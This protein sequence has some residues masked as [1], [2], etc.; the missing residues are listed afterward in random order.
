[1]T[2]GTS[3][4]SASSIAAEIGK[5]QSNLSIRD[6][7]QDT[8]ILNPSNSRQTFTL[9]DTITLTTQDTAVADNMNLQGSNNFEM[10]E[11]KSYNKVNRIVFSSTSSSRVEHTETIGR[12]V[13]EISEPN[14]CE[15]LV[16]GSAEI[17]CKRVGNDIVWYVGE[18]LL[19]SGVG[20]SRKEGTG[21]SG[22]DV[23][24]ARLVGAAANTAAT[25][26]VTYSTA[27]TITGFIGGV[28][29]ANSSGSTSSNLVSTNTKIGFDFRIN[30]DVETFG[31]G[32]AVV[33]VYHVDF[34]VTIPD[35]DPR[36]FR[37]SASPIK[38]QF[39]SNYQGFNQ[40]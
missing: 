23:E 13:G 22:S 10:S 37:F 7:A 9:S 39:T 3:N 11:F 32:Q 31:N 40:C 27:H 5:S 6:A 1:M 12:D 2:I 38:G 35:R 24:C 20:T 14:Q 15:C 18:G 36:V 17:Y 8:L 33:F 26:S 4:V 28:P 21:F 25:V 34:T 19:S 16:R 30:A 29:T